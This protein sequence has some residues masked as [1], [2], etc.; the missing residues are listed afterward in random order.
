MEDPFAGPAS[1]D[2]HHQ[3]RA[4]GRAPEA[5]EPQGEGPLRRSADADRLQAE[6]D[7]TRAALGRYVMIA[8]LKATIA[9]FAGD[10]GWSRVRPPLV[11]LDS[12]QSKALASELR[13]LGLA[14]AGLRDSVA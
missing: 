5:L 14:M 13:S 4:F 6:L 8:A 12:A 11:E 1:V 9:D 7:A 10:P 2:L 3:P